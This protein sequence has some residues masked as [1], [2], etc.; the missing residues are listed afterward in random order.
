MITVL[1]VAMMVVAIVMT[2]TIM[3]VV[4]TVDNHGDVCDRDHDSCDWNCDEM[5]VKNCGTELL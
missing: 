2:T 3:L 1:V 4:V 5:V